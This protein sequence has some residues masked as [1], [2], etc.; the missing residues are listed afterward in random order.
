M[1]DKSVEKIVFCSVGDLANIE[2]YIVSTMEDIIMVSKYQ[3]EFHQCFG[4]YCLSCGG[5]LVRERETA[6]DYTFL[7]IT[8][9]IF[10]G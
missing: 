2:G 4:N 10:P 5:S 8:D 6:L 1:E 3:G 9:D 7:C